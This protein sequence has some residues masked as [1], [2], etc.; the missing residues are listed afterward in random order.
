LDRRSVRDLLLF[1]KT[2]SSGVEA[3]MSI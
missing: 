1:S 3:V 2:C